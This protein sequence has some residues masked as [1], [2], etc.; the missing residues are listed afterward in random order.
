MAC[1]CASK[2]MKSARVGRPNRYWWNAEIAEARSKCNSAKRRWSRARWRADRDM[3]EALREDY[4]TLRKSL[5]FLI[6][7]AKIKA[8]EELISTIEEDPWG[9]PYRLV[10]RLGRPST[11]VTEALSCEELDGLLD[12]LFPIGGAHDPAL[13]WRDK[14][15]DLEMAEV[16]VAEVK[17]A[18]KRGNPGSAPGPDGLTLAILKRAPERFLHALRRRSPHVFVREFFQLDGK[19]RG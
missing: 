1:D 7:D 10:L 16:T 19:G 12:T 11:S 4:R 2:R 3:V 17:N 18:L 14:S 6:R 5:R 8:W 15:V 9:L 13:I